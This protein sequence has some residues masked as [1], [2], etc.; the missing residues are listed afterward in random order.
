MKTKL[1]SAIIEVTRRCPYR[2]IFCS[3]RSVPPYMN[4]ALYD[5]EESI[6]LRVCKEIIDLL[7]SNNE[8]GD[9]AV[10]V[11]G[12]EPG[13]IPGLVIDAATIVIEHGVIV[14]LFTS[15][16]LAEAIKKIIVCLA[17]RVGWSR[18]RELFEVHISLHTLS[19]EIH[20]KLTGIETLE[21]AKRDLEIRLRIIRE[22]SEMG[23]RVGVHFLVTRL[24]YREVCKIVETV[25]KLGVFMV[26]LLR[27][28]PQGRARENRKILELSREEW[29]EFYRLD[30]QLLEKYGNLIRNGCPINWLFLIREDL[31]YRYPP[32]K[33]AAGETHIAIEPDG[34]VIPCSAFKDLRHIYS[35][36]NVY[37]QKL[38]DILNSEERERFLKIKHHEIPEKCRK[39]RHFTYCGAKCIAQRIYNDIKQP[40]PLC[41][42]LHGDSS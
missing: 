42:I 23:I 3:S 11:S 35:F 29:L 37:K 24:N 2:C 16:T 17:E 1:N 22:L 18:V 36:G 13:L 9:P 7:T 31:A 30:L 39:C 28:V 40:D 5:L 15:G 10:E 4:P 8:K 6:V 19:P 21:A 32:P 38:V 14:K 41:T 27:L 25:H 20:K 12:G 26:S 33:C 34:S